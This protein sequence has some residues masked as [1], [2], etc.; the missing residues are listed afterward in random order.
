MLHHF[1]TDIFGLRMQAF[2]L[3]LAG[4]QDYAEISS[5]WLVCGVWYVLFTV[6]V[7]AL[8]GQVARWVDQLSVRFARRL[9]EKVLVALPRTKR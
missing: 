7:F 6:L 3:H 2:L 8:A 5:Y 4:L 9:E 1:C